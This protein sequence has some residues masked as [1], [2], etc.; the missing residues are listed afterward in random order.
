LDEKIITTFSELYIPSKTL[1]YGNYE[2]KL[3]VTMVNFPRV[4][5]SS[6]VYVRIT[7]SGI[8]ANLIQLGTSMIT[9]GYQQ[10]LIFDPG[11]YSIDPDENIF[12]ASVSNTPI[13]ILSNLCHISLFR[14]IGNTHIIV[15]FMICICLQIPSY[16]LI[17][18]IHYVCPI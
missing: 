5:S 12:N 10:D 6:S 16:Q 7:Q 9:R 2:L 18:L 3:T 1:Q 15:K 14:R 17:H 8:V 11:T 13:N 4:R